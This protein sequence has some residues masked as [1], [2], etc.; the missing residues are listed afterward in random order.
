MQAYVAASVFFYFKGR[1]GRLVFED[2]ENFDFLEPT[3]L[4]NLVSFFRASDKINLIDECSIIA[5][6][7][8]WDDEKIRELPTDRRREYLD[9]I[10]DLYE[11]EKEAMEK[12]NRK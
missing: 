7:W 6:R 2:D 4:I 9:V 8:K 10:I 11:R 1:D 12:A 5:E 3:Y